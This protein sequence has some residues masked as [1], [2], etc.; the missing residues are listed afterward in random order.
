MQ[1]AL[2]LAA[3]GTTRSGMCAAL[4]DGV[5]HRV[6]L[7]MYSSWLLSLLQVFMHELSGKQTVGEELTV[8]VCLRTGC[9]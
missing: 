9:W 2:A 7:G 1:P 6:A 8:T 5:G 4:F 3:Q